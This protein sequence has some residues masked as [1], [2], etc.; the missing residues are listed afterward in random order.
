MGNDPGASIVA[1]SFDRRDGQQS[2]NLLTES[3]QTA[4]RTAIY[5]A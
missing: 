4:G 2:S 1:P 5:M 3:R